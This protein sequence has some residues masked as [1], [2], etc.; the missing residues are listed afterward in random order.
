MARW[1]IEE[2][3]DFST[4]NRSLKEAGIWLGSESNFFYA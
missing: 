2:A 4:R 1:F 3:A